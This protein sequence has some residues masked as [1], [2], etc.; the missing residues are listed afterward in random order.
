MSDKIELLPDA[1]LLLSSLRSVGYKSETAIS[2]IIDNCISA[3]ATE[4]H[5][6]FVW[7]EEKS[8]ILI[9][10]NG[11]GMD[12][13]TLIASMKIG[14]ADPSMVRNNDDLGRFGMGMKTAAFS[15]GKKLSVFSKRR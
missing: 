10:D 13:E 3:H 8:C 14:S 9:Y 7:S 11:E 15:L 2:D 1:H 12:H 4:I 6:D 5:V